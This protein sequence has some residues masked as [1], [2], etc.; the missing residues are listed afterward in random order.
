MQIQ[1]TVGDKDIRT[2]RK[3]REFFPVAGGL[4]V[5]KV[6]L[7]GSRFYVVRELFILLAFMAILFSIVAAFLVLGVLV[8]EG[9]RCGLRRMGQTNRTIA[10]PQQEGQKV[11]GGI[12]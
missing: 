9:V 3:G 1:H 4:L 10:P 11:F 6:V 5:V 2:G 12:S 8:H 7:L